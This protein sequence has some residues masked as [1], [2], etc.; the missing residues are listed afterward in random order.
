[1]RILAPLALVGV[2]ALPAMAEEPTAT[3]TVSGEGTVYV[4][5]DVA[6]ISLG[7]TVNGDTAKAALDANSVALAAV[8]EKLKAAGIDDKDIQTSGLFLGPVYDYSASSGAPQAVLGCTAS[9]NVTVFVRAVDQVGPVLDASVNDGANVLNGVNFGL[10]DQKPAVD[11]ARDLAVADAKRK[12]DLLAKASGVTVGKI[13]N[14]TEQGGY[15][16]PMPLASAALDKSAGVPV[17]AGQMQI[18]TSVTMTF[19]IGQ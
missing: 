9:N 10:L 14:I 8:I 5:P 18:G 17:A 15:A 16:P 3:M 4:V 2:L 19:A 12:A 11:Q 1:M 13:L 7:V 6:T